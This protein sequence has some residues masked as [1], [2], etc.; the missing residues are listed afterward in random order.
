MGVIQI[1]NTNLLLFLLKLSTNFLRNLKI[2]QI[3]L[4]SNWYN[5]NHVSLRKDSLFQQSLSE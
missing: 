3:F 1:P 4:Y 5:Q 2:E